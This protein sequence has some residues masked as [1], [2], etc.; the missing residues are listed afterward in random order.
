MTKNKLL[1]IYDALADARDAFEHGMCKA[2]ITNVPS[3]ESYYEYKM[4]ATD[5]AMRITRAELIDKYHCDPT[6]ETGEKGRNNGYN[7]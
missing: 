3:E 5:R 7:G 2:R 1:V 4:I 6:G